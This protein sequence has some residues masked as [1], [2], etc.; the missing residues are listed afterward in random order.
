MRQYISA[1]PNCLHAK[2]NPF[3]L[4]Q[5]FIQ[6]E[7]LVLS[8]QI[9]QVAIFVSIN[10]PNCASAGSQLF[11]QIQL[12]KLSMNQGQQL[13]LDLQ[14]NKKRCKSVGQYQN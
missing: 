3:E 5:S 10:N 9:K 7:Q 11:N 2:D 1:I 12:E 8:Q 13:Q 6:L 14:T 4:Q